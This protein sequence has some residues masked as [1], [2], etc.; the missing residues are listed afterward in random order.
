MKK[1]VCG[2]LVAGLAAM[3]G[4]SWAAMSCADYASV[5]SITGSGG[6]FGNSIAAAPFRV[7]AG[8]TLVY[9]ITDYNRA[10]GQQG[11]ANATLSLETGSTVTG[12]VSV[13]ISGA[14]GSATFP[15]I[16]VPV[17]VANEFA[18]ATVNVPGTVSSS[19]VYHVSVQCTPAGGGGSGGAAATG[20]DELQDGFVRAVA[21]RGTSAVNGLVNRALDAAFDPT[22]A[23]ALALGYA[24]TVVIEATP[25]ELAAAGFTLWGAAGYEATIPGAGSW[26]GGQMSAAGGVNFRAA[27]DLVLGVFGSAGGS[28][29][30]KGGDSVA[31]RGLGVGGLAAYRLDE[32]WRVQAIA[33]AQGLRYDVGSGGTSGA[34]DALVLSLEGSIKGRIAVSAQVDFEPRLGVMVLSENQAGYTDSASTAHAAQSFVSSEATAGGVFK[35]YPLGGADMVLSAGGQASVGGAGLSGGL[36]AGVDLTLA[37]NAKL[38][39]EG[40][41]RTIGSANGT[42]AGLTARLAGAL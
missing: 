30:K 31:S 3:P 33:S 6:L 5:T 39:L 40:T 21:Q 11:A 15:A 23:G 24:G 37:P 19:Y 4:A 36:Q 42:S 14:T 22:D 41:L 29:H 34:F 1:I 10:P 16:T 25:D 32:S 20:L 17:G 28:A 9:T 26:T 2:V 18:D 38:G 27:E 13:A 35:F 12:P 8:D 7:S